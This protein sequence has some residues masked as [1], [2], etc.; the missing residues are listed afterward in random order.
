MKWQNKLIFIFILVF[1]SRCFIYGQSSI[2]DS[3]IHLG[4][5]SFRLSY[6]IPFFDLKQRFGPD[7]APGINAGYKLKSG[8]NFQYSY[9]F[10]FGQKVKETSMLNYISSSKGYLINGQGTMEPID[11]E[12]RGFWTYVS[13][14]KIWNVIG[15]NPNSGIILQV[16]A[17]LLQHKI[18]F[19][20]QR[21]LVSLP[22]LEGEYSKGY[23]R[24][25]NGIMWVQSIGY[26]HFSNYNLGNFRFSL[27]FMEAFTKNRRSW[28]FDE[29]GP[30]NQKRLDILAGFSITLDIPVY[31]RAP[32]EFYVN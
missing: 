5:I 26:Q 3:A 18:F 7:I 32:D 27:D 17:G 15:P 10:I 24:L 21:S 11:F 2:K 19:N 14:G 25:S 16:G 12:E 31:K 6:Q 30:D 1:V 9:G 22:Q 13:L 4:I 20:Y 8:W 28:N 23:D 29:F